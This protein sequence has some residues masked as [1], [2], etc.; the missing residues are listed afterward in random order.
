MEYT[1]PP[2]CAPETGAVADE[3]NVGGGNGK[4]ADTQAMVL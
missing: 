3:L 2:P 1:A 4:D